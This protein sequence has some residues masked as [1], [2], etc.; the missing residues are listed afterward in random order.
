MINFQPDICLPKDPAGWSF[1]LM[2]HYR[3]HVQMAEL[4]GLLT[5]AV[6]IPQYS[7][8]DWKDDPQIVQQWLVDHEAVHEQLRFATNTTGVDLSLVD[9]SKDDEFLDW[10]DDHAL[11]HTNFRQ[12]LGII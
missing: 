9:F 4:C 8:A 7:F 10:L 3:E 1:W 6:N 12:V 5:P 11:E 2:G